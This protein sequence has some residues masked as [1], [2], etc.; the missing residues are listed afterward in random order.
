[1]GRK[2][3]A[4]WHGLLASLPCLLALGGQSHRK[5]FDGSKFNPPASSPMESKSL[6]QQ[7][8]AE[9]TKAGLLLASDREG[10]R[11][12]FLP[13]P[14]PQI[15]HSVAGHSTQISNTSPPRLTWLRCALFLNVRHMRF[16]YV[17]TTGVL[18]LTLLLWLSCQVHDVVSRFQKSKERQGVYVQ[19]PFIQ[20]TFL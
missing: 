8:S 6:I 19:D 3:E 16:C 5:P 15:L 2:E 10:L 9:R 11:H 4:R 7:C 17:L 18:E 20:Q 13:T 14:A 1:M 12:Q